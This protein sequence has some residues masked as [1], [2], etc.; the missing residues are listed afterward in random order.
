MPTLNKYEEESMEN[1]SREYGENTE[2]GMKSLDL[3]VQNPKVID[4]SYKSQ[5]KTQPIANNGPQEVTTVRGNFN[6]NIF[7]GR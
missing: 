3:F 6:A 4:S 7:N 1:E 5:T 2:I